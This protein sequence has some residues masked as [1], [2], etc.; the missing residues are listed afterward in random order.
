MH[1]LLKLS[2]CLKFKCN[3]ICKLFYKI[4]NSQNLY[5]QVEK[6]YLKSWSKCMSQLS[7]L[8]GVLS[9]CDSDIIW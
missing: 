4:F 9:Y 5:F 2:K 1:Q 6:K 7:N 3:G 8:V